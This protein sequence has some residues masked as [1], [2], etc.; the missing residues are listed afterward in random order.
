M[1]D[2][3]CS[4]CAEPWDMDTLHDEAELR[5]ESMPGATYEDVYAEVRRDFQLKGC[6][7]IGGRCPEKVTAAQ[8][9]NAAL[10]SAAERSAGRRPRRRG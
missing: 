5:Q 6:A 3:Y 2:I 10:A 1:A 4:K 8:K 9:T 7:A